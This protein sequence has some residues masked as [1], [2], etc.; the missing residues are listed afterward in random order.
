MS[1]VGVA[2]PARQGRGAPAVGSDRP[3]GRPATFLSPSAGLRSRDPRVRVV[4]SPP[5]PLSSPPPGCPQRWPA[6]SITRRPD[7]RPDSDQRPAP[8][9]PPTCPGSH[10]CSDGRQ[11]SRS[12][13][14]AVSVRQP[15]APK[16][17]LTRGLTKRL[18]LTRR[19][20]C[21]LMGFA[22]LSSV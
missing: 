20:A 8:V 13:A 15:P 2:G 1:P 4:S 14:G 16:W 10:G 12:A 18:L 7:A 21:G 22:L 5:R 3:G 9:S 11:P 17:N 19:R 6:A